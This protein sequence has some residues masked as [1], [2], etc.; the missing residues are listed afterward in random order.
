M[1]PAV[2]VIMPALNS[3]ATIT[4][5]IHSV[6]QQTMQD[7]ELLVVDDGSCDETGTMTS[8]LAEAEP[9]I[10]FFRQN[11][12]GPSAARNLA[13]HHAR[14]RFTCFLDADD[15]WFPHALETLHAAANQNSTG[16]AY[17][18]F[19]YAHA[20]GT[21]TDLQPGWPDCTIGL[22]ELLEDRHFPIHAWMIRRDRL[23]D[24]RFDTSLGSWEDLDLFQK[25]AIRGVRFEPV[26]EIV[27]RYRLTPGSQSRKCRLG[28]TSRMIV[29]D[30]GF[31]AARALGWDRRDPFS[32]ARPA[33]DL[34]ELRLGRLLAGHCHTYAAASLLGDPSASKTRAMEILELCPERFRAML[35]VSAR[36]AAVAACH[37]IPYSQGRL[38]DFWVDHWDLCF[39]H[40]LAWWERLAAAGLAAP[41]LPDEARH[42]L[43]SLVDSTSFIPR[44]LADACPPYK[45]IVLHGLGRNGR[46]VAR[47]LVSRGIAFTVHDDGINA[48]Q[49]ARELPD[50]PIRFQGPAAELENGAFHI[51][52]MLDSTAYESRF[53]LA[54]PCVRWS[55]VLEREAQRIREDLS[56]RPVR[57]AAAA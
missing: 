17:A 28:A 20:D 30:R 15:T 49:T 52:S 55:D 9:R 45:P 2:S 50:L 27:A 43:I 37:Q 46:R 25:L 24:A 8:S 3:A 18:R 57:S 35:R 53:R 26:R 34:S 12:A 29:Q 32:S 19:E 51:F 21:P 54:A 1:T 22:P 48:D 14:G 6:Q 40:A 33:V 5:A 41:S 56:N 47:E 16:A 13:L 31:L 38:S 36:E 4:R 10:R 11:H 44:L 42:E 7:W 39:P 23:G